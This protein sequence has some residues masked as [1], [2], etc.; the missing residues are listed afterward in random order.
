MA[1]DLDATDIKLINRLQDE[2]RITNAALAEE[3]G[4]SASGCVR[5]VQQL[6]TAGVIAGYH[7]AVSPEH[8]GLS[9]QT[10]V[11]VTLTG[12][13]RTQIKTFIDDVKAWPE[14]VACYSVTGDADF[15]LQIMTP[16]LKSY[17]NFLIDRLTQTVVIGSVKTHVVLGV[18]KQSHRL[19]LEHLAW[20]DADQRS[21]ETLPKA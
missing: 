16:D 1:I 5:R 7:A 21:A 17:H 3:A 2:G 18:E 12:H 20:E 6:E 13:G 15:L 8:V 14:V 11:G 19:P 10:F 9:L 4:L